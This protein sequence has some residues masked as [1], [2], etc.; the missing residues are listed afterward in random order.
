MESAT[1]PVNSSD[2]TSESPV[3]TDAWAVPSEDIELVL[4]IRNSPPGVDS[5]AFPELWSSLSAFT[6]ARPFPFDDAG[7]EVS[8]FD[9][10]LG[11][12]EFGE[13][14]DILGV[15]ILLSAIRTPDGPSTIPKVVAARIKYC[16]V[17]PV[18]LVL[19]AFKA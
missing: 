8:T 15:G 6:E 18:L 17:V 2:G 16:I 9:F 7:E 12:E 19:F 5:G 3:V 4:W 14:K 13:V 1:F 11:E 10:S